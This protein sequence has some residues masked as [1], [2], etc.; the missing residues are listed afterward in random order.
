MTNHNEKNGLHEFYEERFSSRPE[1]LVDYCFNE[2]SDTAQEVGIK[3]ESIAGSVHYSEGK[4]SK[5]RDKIG[6]FEKKHAKKVMVWGSLKRSDS[7]LIFPTLT[8]NN[9]VSSIGS[10]AW[11]GLSALIDLYKRQG[12][13][14]TDAK[15][16]QWKKDQA[17]KSAERALKRAEVERIE[18]E[19]LAR[20]QAEREAYEQAWF[21]GGAI[22]FKFL[23]PQTQLEATDTVELLGDEDGT[24]P[25]LQRKQISDI[26]Q[27]VELKRMR[28]RHGIFTAVPLYDI[29]GEFQGV[30]RLYDKK[31]YQGTG[32]KMDGLHCVI[33]DID[34][35]K[36]V[37]AVEGFATGA[38]V[39]LAEHSVKNQVAVIITLSVGNLSKVLFKYHQRFPQ[40]RIINAADDDQFTRAGNAG[41]LAALDLHREL[42]HWAVLPDFTELDPEELQKAKP[43]DWNDYHC[44]FGLKATYRDLRSREVFKAA[45]DYFEYR[46]QRISVSGEQAEKAALDAIG[47]GMLLVPIKFS[48]KQIIE[49][50]L[51]ELPAGFMF[52]HFKIKRRAIWLAKLKLNEVQDL[53]GFSAAALAK[54]N[55]KYLKIPGVRASHGGTLL[56][57]HLADLVESLDGFVIVRAPMGSGKTEKLIAPVMKNSNRAAYIAHR[58]S[59]LDDAATRLEIQHY[60]QVTSIEMLDV[61]HLACCVNSLTKSRFYNREERSWFTTIDTLC[62]DEASQVIR[63]TT[64]GPVDSPVRVMDALLEAMASAKRVLLC[65]ADANDS[66]IRLCEEA[67]PGKPITIIEVT[68]TMDHITVKHSDLDTVWQKALDLILAGNRVLVANDSAESAK[69]L[70]AL[71][72]EKRPEAKL[73]LIH[74]E[75][76][77]DPAVDAFLADPCGEAIHY[78]ALIYSPA[79]SSGVSMTIPHFQHH[80][81]IFSGNTIGPSDAVQMLRRDR[82]ARNYLI[83]IG[84][85]NSQR[86]TDREAIFRGWLAADVISC[87]FEETTTEILLRR[88]KTAFDELYLSSTANENRA[89]NNFANNLLMMLYAD[90]YKVERVATDDMLARASRK[91]RKAAGQLVFGRRMQLIESVK[92]PNEEEFAKLDRMEVRSEA[93]AAQIDRYQIER[94]LGVSQIT[95]DDVAFYDDRG[96]SKVIALELLQS[97]EEQARAYDKAQRKARVVLS[98]TRF[99]TASRAFLLDAFTTLGVDPQTGAGEFSRAACEQILDRILASQE[100]TELYNSL[101]LG[102]LV[103]FGRKRGCAT[104]LVKSILLRLGLGVKNRKSNGKVLYQINPEHWGFM[105]RYVTNRAA[106]GVHSLTTHEHAAPHTPKPGLDAVEPSSAPDREGLQSEGIATDENYP[107]PVRERIYAAARRYFTPLGSTLAEIVEG[108]AP[109]IAEGFAR[110]GADPFSIGFT[111]AYAQRLQQGNH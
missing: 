75:S 94:Q 92:T 55:V 74:R 51:E 27:F 80:I 70:A 73:L 33:G 105:F 79:I 54:P 103:N 86:E 4:G 97:T 104:T 57:D 67:A 14:V 76:K 28:D 89:K 6:T 65:D 21:R 26:A 1:S 101:K 82:T 22:E 5:Y 66:V 34:T 7:G 20:I 19:I 9:N 108:L 17:A 48:T 60:Q 46:L 102:A 81:G 2:I 40:L 64:T 71:V 39:F 90:G 16:E 109:E 68:G 93:E 63:H 47:A 3:W 84:H 15:H 87:E 111:L 78:D 52:S 95:P 91:N 43:T 106:I 98:K 62:I 30:Q 110:E 23:D 107:L 25:Y 72:A 96:I 44:L 88:Q 83:G 36:R 61:S 69:K 8:F 49:R 24:A 13:Q 56:P 12:G 42:G 45:K 50:V 41:R 100:S 35:A 29:D 18:A 32:V 31:K 77:S 37:Y 85:S 99:K 38:S 59:L 53:R 11:S 58:I 10:V